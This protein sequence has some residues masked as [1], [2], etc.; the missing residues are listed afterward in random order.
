MNITKKP[1][2]SPYLK[3]IKRQYTY[4]SIEDSEVLLAFER[5][6]TDLRKLSTFV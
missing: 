3:T 2:Y 6:K 1:P 4:S 5:N